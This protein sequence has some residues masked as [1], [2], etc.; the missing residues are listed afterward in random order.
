MVG[1]VTGGDFDHAL[2]NHI[3]ERVA[4]RSFG[5]NHLHGFAKGDAGQMHVNLRVAGDA[6]PLKCLPVHGD[7]G[8]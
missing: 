7:V 3:A 4:A 8:P 6:R 2:I 1:Q 5:Q